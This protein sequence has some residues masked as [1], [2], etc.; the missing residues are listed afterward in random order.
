MTEITRKDFM[1]IYRGTIGET[2][3]LVIYDHGSFLHIYI[4]ELIYLTRFVSYYN[5][6]VKY[7]THR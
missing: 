2:Q 7:F 4:D 1:N 5:D 6:T 3:H